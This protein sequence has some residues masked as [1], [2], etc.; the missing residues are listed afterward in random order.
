MQKIAKEKKNLITVKKILFFLSKHILLYCQN[1]KINVTKAI[2]HYIF[3]LFLRYKK[4]HNFFNRLDSC[5]LNL[6]K[7]S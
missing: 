3:S 1:K 5:N 6:W 4:I 7:I 2:C